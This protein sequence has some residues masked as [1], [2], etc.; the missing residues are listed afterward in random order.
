MTD[1][2]AAQHGGAADAAFAALLDDQGRRLIARMPVMA[3]VLGLERSMAGPDAQARLDDLSPAGIDARADL[4]AAFA[5]ALA[6]IDRAGL[7]PENRIHYDVLQEVYARTTARAA[8]PWAGRGF[9]GEMGPYA[10][11]QL[12][13]AHLELPHMLSVEH[14]VDDRLDAEG[15][16][17]R[18]EALG[19]AL[20]HVAD[21]VAADAGRGVIPPRF[22]VQAT[23]DVIH[24][25]LAPDADDHVLITS[26][27]DKLA[28][29][30]ALSDA[31][32][33]R[34]LD[35]AKR[36]WTGAAVPGFERLAG[37]L[38]GLVAAASDRI[39]MAGLPDGDAFYA[40]MIASQADSTLP[41]R[42]IHRTGLDEV[43][44]ISGDM[45]AL[46]KGQGLTEGPVGARMAALSADPR[47]R[48]PAGPEGERALMGYIED[49]IGGMTARLPDY[50]G[51]LPPFGLEVRPVPG[52]RA[53]NDS[54]AY[55]TGPAMD[56]SRPG[57]YWMNLRD[58]PATPRFVL[59][60]LTYHEAIP[61]H[62]LQIALAMGKADTPLLR[63]IFYFN[64]FAEGW[65]LYAELL[66]KE[67]GLYAD[68]PFG[69]LGRLSDELFRAVRLVVDTGIHAMGWDLDRAV[70]YMTDTLGGARSEILS[71]ARRYA[72]MPGQALGY[73]IG[74][75][76][77]LD[78]RAK[79]RAALGAR[80]DIRAFHDTVLAQGNVSLG[81]LDRHL[82]DWI[83]G[84]NAS[85]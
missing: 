65:A 80:F 84:R 2:G 62:H 45:D 54:L 72:V 46:L 48:F 31:D 56:G 17:A 14:R 40:L 5:Q 63:Q 29:A 73:K 23:R 75:L 24:T 60:T 74:M 83:A 71:E 50:F 81:A 13:G 18:L 68:D 36:V 34:F 12:T 69:D 1:H 47:F 44:R 58:V 28:A 52:Y 33:A 43:A 3:T 82:D 35:E 51:T 22:A 6:G 57:I 38:D 76:K 37:T 70:A 41:A 42:E 10:V 27:R 4:Y 16:I 7:G 32:R 8:Y 11:T 85:A 66:A 53:A 61:G 30:A 67:A 64:S 21:H 39:G 20:G 9:V 79:A 15:Y 77:I 19:A 25:Y 49:L 59:P 26:F 78:L 55:Y